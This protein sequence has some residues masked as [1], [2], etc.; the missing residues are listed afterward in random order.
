MQCWVL[1]RY[2]YM[3]NITVQSDDPVVGLQY[4]Q[5]GDKDDNE[6]VDE[7]VSALLLAFSVYACKVPCN[8]AGRGSEH[9]CALYT[10]TTWL[11]SLCFKAPRLSP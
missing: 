10:G 1:T 3:H 7:S 9:L 2:S 8:I 4:F 11:S 5:G 6:T